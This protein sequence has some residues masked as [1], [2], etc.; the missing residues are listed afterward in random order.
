MG[1]N[2]IV[3]IIRYG[4]AFIGI[5]F[6]GIAVGLI[7]TGK[8]NRTRCTQLVSATVVD[9][10]RMNSTSTDGSSMVSWFPVY[11]YWYRGT[12]ITKRSKVGSADQN[13]Y[14]GQ[15]VE[16]YVNPQNPNEFYCPLEKR[17]VL[18][19]IFLGVGCVLLVISVFV[20]IV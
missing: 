5:V 13:F 2:W 4:F 11:E 1:A 10:E 3:Q 17:K 9:M 20:T 19:A 8:R 7:Y 12:Q 16:L 18:E 6:L 14:V 15:K